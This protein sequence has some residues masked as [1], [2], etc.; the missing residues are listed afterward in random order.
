MR[1]EPFAYSRP[2]GLDEAV[3]LIA[4]GGTPLAG[5][6]SLVQSMK[7]RSAA[8]QHLVDINDLSEL[9]GISQ[10]ADWLRIGALTR[11]HE[12]ISAA[13]VHEF[14][15]WLVQAARLLGDVQ[16]RNRGTVG[17]NLAFGD[18]RGNFPVALLASR[19]R[20]LVFGEHGEQTVDLPDF[21]VRDDSNRALVTHIELPINRQARGAYLEIS[22]QPNE[23]SLVN[24]AVV[25][26]PS[27][28]TVAVGGV[29]EFPRRLPKV[30][31]ALAGIVDYTD[32]VITAAL[33]QL[34]A[35]TLSYPADGQTPSAYR[36][37]VLPTLIRRTIEQAM[38]SS[39]ADR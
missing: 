29:D 15:P 26:T 11:H 33:G 21:F 10:V 25:I 20:V 5:G 36:R 7:L 38:P 19:A 3:S 24:A 34:G 37:S 39:G 35:E 13:L 28:A 16:V 12:I 1:T 23:L 4:A 2:K 14:A 27:M 18:A 31:E 30:E 17:G 9:R 32:A 6:Q 8:P 22:R